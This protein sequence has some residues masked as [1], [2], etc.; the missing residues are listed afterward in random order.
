[1][2]LS[3]QHLAEIVASI[4]PALMST[5]QQQPQLYQ[6]S[7]QQQ[8]HQQQSQQ[9]QSHQQQ[10]HQQQPHQETTTTGLVDTRSYSYIFTVLLTIYVVSTR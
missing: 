5:I 9:Q 3:Q 1:M 7:H 6:Q 8:S 4:L 2:S 10:P